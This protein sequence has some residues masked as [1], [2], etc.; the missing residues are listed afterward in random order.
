MEHRTGFTATVDGP[1]D[2]VV[3]MLRLWVG[4]ERFS[5]RDR[6]AGMEAVHDG[7]ATYLFCF[8]EGIRGRSSCLVEGTIAEDM[9][10]ADARLRP[11]ATL[12]EA[13]GYRLQLEYSPIGPDGRRSAEET[14]LT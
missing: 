6:M 3:A 11:L 13:R 4:D 12:A 5:I 1:F 10:E 7:N 8:E 9:A 14:S 2:E